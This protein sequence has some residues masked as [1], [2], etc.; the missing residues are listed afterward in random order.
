MLSFYSFSTIHF[1]NGQEKMEQHIKKVISSRCK[2][3]VERGVSHMEQFVFNISCCTYVSIFFFLNVEKKM[4][5]KIGCYEHN[6]NNYSH[7]TVSYL[8]VNQSYCG[9]CNNFPPSPRELIHLYP[10]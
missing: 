6:H 10:S 2:A 1:L 3:K 9:K 4:I 5:V 7:V 8:G